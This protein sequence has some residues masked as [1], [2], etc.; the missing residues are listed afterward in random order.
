MTSR[1]GKGKASRQKYD[2]LWA[3]T[4]D[5]ELSSAAKLAAVVLLLKFRNH[6]TGQCN[7]SFGA[8]AAMLGRTRRAVIPAVQELAA[9]GWIRIESTG[10]GRKSNTNRVRFCSD[11]P[12]GEVKPASPVGVKST[13]PVK[14][15][16][17]RVKSASHEPSRTTLPL[18]R[19]E[20]EERVPVRAPDG[21]HES[22]SAF[23]NQFPLRVDRKAALA[24]F[25]KIVA[26][27]EA[28]AQELIAAAMR[29]AAERTDEDPKFTK[30][31]ANWLKDG[32][33]TDGPSGKANG[34]GHHRRPG[35]KVS[36]VNHAFENAGFKP[37]EGWQDG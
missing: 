33:W 20:G 2:L 8:L 28:T 5:P 32:R 25:E 17:G 13:S 37:P 7:P 23:W 30:R 31:P 22:F 24:Q 29:Y 6:K 18:G 12:S 21:A 15:T 1:G 27:G 4:A 14:H 34:A 3:I 9:R 10:G 26:E 35:R 16:A 36:L 19:E 11:E